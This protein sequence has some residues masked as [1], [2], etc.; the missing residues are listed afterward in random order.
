M[1]NDNLIKLVGLKPKKDLAESI[2]IENAKVKIEVKFLRGLG[3]RPV[4]MEGVFSGVI[5]A[6]TI[7]ENFGDDKIM[8]PIKIE[9][10]LKV[11][12]DKLKMTLLKEKR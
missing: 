3:N 5:E 11:K 6:Y 1:N 2:P 12:A 9:Y 4:I 8:E 7:S 10:K